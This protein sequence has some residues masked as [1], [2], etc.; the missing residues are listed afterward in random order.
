[1]PTTTPSD[2]PPNTIG[3]FCRACGFS[4]QVT[5]P[6]AAFEKHLA[7]CQAPINVIARLKQRIIE[8]E[9]ELEEAQREDP[10]PS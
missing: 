10:S 5:D 6:K 8:L 2:P 1:M 4:D 7:E 9:S 3:V